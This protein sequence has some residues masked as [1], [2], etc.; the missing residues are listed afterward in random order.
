V[1]ELVRERWIDGD[2]NNDEQRA[3]YAH[4]S[5]VLRPEDH[6]ARLDRLLWKEDSAAA[7]RMYPYTG[8]DGQALGEARLALANLSGNAETLV[9]RLPQR[10]QQD[11]GLLYERLRWRVRNNLD[12]SADDILLRVPQS[13]GQNLGH[14]EAWW[15]QRQIMIRRALERHDPALAYR[16]AAAHG[17][18]NPKTLVQGE[19]L[20][21]WLALRFL[22]KPQEAVEHFATLYDNA[23][24]PISRA[25]GAYW[26][27]RAYEAANN[28]PEAEQSYE[29]AAA[30]DVTYYGQLAAARLS[31][32]P[33]IRAT[34][35]PAIPPQVRAASF[36][37]D[38]IRAAERLTAMGETERARSFFHAATEAAL[39]RV[40]FVLL[41]ELAYQIKRPDLAIMAAKAA[42]QKN[43][44][45]AAGGYP[46][47]DISLPRQPEPAFIHALIRQESMFN[48]DATSPAGARGL[49]QLMPRTA[50][51]T[52]KHM[53]IKYKEKRL[54]DP[55][56]NV[57][58]GVNF[59]QH[60]LDSFNG[61][62]VMALAGYNAGPGRVHEWIAEFGDPRSG[63]VDPID[64][65]E[66]MPIN[67]TRNYV[68]RII[69][70]LQI[71]RA[72]L[73]GGQAPLRIMADLKR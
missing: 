34:P 18:T 57:K 2:M 11:P 67:E 72:R 39:Q 52:A 54:T 36:A 40:D 16:L 21:G 68:Q 27:G 61:S 38:T 43:I 56:F 31:P 30:L 44:L 37:R 7:R 65:I 33:V 55:D 41:T 73:N 48:P 49:M 4:F 3:F 45:V 17:Q 71:Y 50:K 12:D 53:G 29:T 10:L 46:L 70:S 32:N 51:D 23:S 9:S 22:N 6:A 58:L 20:A 62:Y 59:V 13:L 42:A 5:N 64:W 8:G 28:K 25:R 26:L 60:Q 66:L 24:T 1:P 47:L 63:A 15:D 14:P 69:E 35:E 19:F